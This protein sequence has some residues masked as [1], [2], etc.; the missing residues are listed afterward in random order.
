MDRSVGRL[1]GLE[2]D[3]YFN[4]LVGWKVDH[5]VRFV[6]RSRRDPAGTVRQRVRKLI[7]RK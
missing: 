1:R 2:S 3:S 7:G 4:R 5:F 6:G